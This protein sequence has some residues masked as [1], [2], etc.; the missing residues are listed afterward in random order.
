MT[1]TPPVAPLPKRHG[2]YCLAND[3]AL[4]WFEAFVRS[5]RHHNPDL[6][7]TVIPY[8]SAMNRLKALQA[9]F[10]FDV[11]PEAKAAQFDAI[12]HR[13]AGQNLPGG[14][15]RKLCTFFGEY[16]TF[17]FL[18]SDIV[19]ARPL[20][21]F[22]AA[23]E[24]AACDFIYFDTDMAMVYTPDFAPK[25]MAEFGSVGFNSG[26]F[27]SRKGC[28][29][30]PEIMQ[31]VALGEQIRDHFS[32]WGEQPFLN[33]LVDITRRRKRAASEL[34][35]GT[36]DKPWARANFKHGAAEDVYRDAGGRIMPFIHWPGCE[37]PTMVRPEVFLR[38]RTLGMGAGG[39]AAYAF[40]FY[41][42]RLR[43]GARE[44]IK[45]STLLAGWM[46]RREQRMA[47]KRAAASVS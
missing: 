45:K 38:F 15:F 27:I 18:D 17:L 37:W 36:T 23:F 11:M 44:R 24:N 39:R 40:H 26:A 29:T 41:Y 32:I 8:N 19:V 1:A 30:E 12:A 16:E 22:F 13:V 25:M 28:F 34:M 4:E 42:R 7:L 47:R 2:V 6:S 10:R 14:T 21:P 46:A 5:F 35:P 3:P 43:A 9:Q 31:A 33:Y 20:A